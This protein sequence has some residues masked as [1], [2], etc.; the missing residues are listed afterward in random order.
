MVKKKDLESKVN[1][2]LVEDEPGARERLIVAAIRL[3]AERG[4]EGVSTRDLVKEAG[5]NISLISYYFGGKEGLYL[6]TIEEFAEKA[7]TDV[8]ALFSGV[9]EQSLT[10]D[11][12]VRLMGQ[13]I[14]QVVKYKFFH[15]HMSQILMREM[16]QGMPYAKA[17]FEKVFN[18]L[19]EQV[20]QFMSLAQKKG[21]VR[22][23]VNV[24]TLFFF[25]IHSSDT[26]FAACK[27]STPFMKK[28]YCFPQ[29]LPLFSRQMK[30]IF[31]EGVLV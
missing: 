24:H 1:P 28:A 7:V 13:F 31:I 22:S 29:E 27:C 8:S 12:Y 18:S 6:K 9:N 11:D 23:D 10:K 20:M 17:V 19:A 26:Y 25:L 15:P 5:V 14:D 16:L 3:F 21:I 4:L 2:V 30:L